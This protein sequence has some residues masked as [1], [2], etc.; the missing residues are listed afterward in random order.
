MVSVNKA[1]IERVQQ[2]SSPKL[3]S[4]VT[5]G[6][7]QAI[8]TGFMRRSIL[9]PQDPNLWAKARFLASEHS[10]Q[11]AQALRHALRVFIARQ[12]GTPGSISLEVFQ[13]QN[14]QVAKRSDIVILASPRNM[15]ETI[16]RG[17]GLPEALERTTLIVLDTSITISQMEAMIY[18]N[19]MPR[20][21]DSQA[22]CCIVRAT[23]N[24]AAAHGASPTIISVSPNSRAN[25]QT[26]GYLNSLF[27]TVGTVTYLDESLMDAAATICR[28]TPTFLALVCEAIIDGAVAGGLPRSQAQSMTEQAV[29][30]FRAL[31][32]MDHRCKK[33]SDLRQMIYAFMTRASRSE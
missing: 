4:I 21:G 28:G 30:S 22:T 32:T 18:F 11:S 7:G 19:G 33:P 5:D 6:I 10:D 2:F 25:G 1:E 12:P 31:L 8:L 15:V 13:N 29:G 9:S 16:L 27:K 17:R 23:P 20:L 24:M 26:L 3:S 14:F